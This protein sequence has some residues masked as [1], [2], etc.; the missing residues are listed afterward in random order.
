M[1]DKK[2]LLYSGGMD[3][4][5]CSKLFEYDELVYVDINTPTSKVEIKRLPSNVKVFN[6]KEL[7]NF[8]IG[9]TAQLPL[10]NLFFVLIGSY[11]GNDIHLGALKGEDARDKDYIFKGQ[12]DAMLNH[13]WGKYN[14]DSYKVSYPVKHLTKADLL[15]EYKNHGFD[16][17]ELFYGTFSCYKPLEDDTE[18]GVCRICLLKWASLAVN[19]A[20]NIGDKR[21]EVREL[22][23]LGESDKDHKLSDDEIEFLTLAANLSDKDLYF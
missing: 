3:S 7:A 21:K 2:V 18:C 8:E 23:K 15:L 13:L 12:C 1:K 14:D 5:I 22:I 6:L 10:R 20:K 9:K 16:L 17:S 4:Y 19:G 11:F